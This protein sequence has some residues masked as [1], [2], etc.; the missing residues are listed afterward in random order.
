MMLFGLAGF[1]AIVCLVFAAVVLMAVALRPWRR[2][3]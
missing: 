1:A 2:A 3:S